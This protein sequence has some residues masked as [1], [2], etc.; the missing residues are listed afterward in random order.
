MKK[1]WIFTTGL[2]LLSFLLFPFGVK[3]ILQSNEDLLYETL[4]KNP[5]KYLESVQSSMLKMREQDL[6]QSEEDRQS[7]IGAASKLSL[8]S[9]ELLRGKAPIQVI[10]YSDLTCFYCKKVFLETL[11][12]LLNENK[13]EF[14]FR[15]APSQNGLKF[16]E[17]FEALRLEKI[18]LAI[19]FHDEILK[20]K[21]F[22][23]V[24]TKLSLTQDQLNNFLKKHSKAVQEKIEEDMELAQKTN[25]QG[26]PLLL[27]NG[28]KVEG[29]IKKDALEHLINQILKKN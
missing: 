21:D 15:H 12:P 18:D 19:K 22:S 14:V 1:L 13:I 29:F 3:F 7:Q 8:R 23:S 24:L 26:T 20:A 5:K 16:S 28:V 6:R 11:Q 10:A 17:Y 25:L 2:F 27:V 4:Q 9:S